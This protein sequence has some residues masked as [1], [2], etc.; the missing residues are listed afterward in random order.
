MGL[1]LTNLRKNA[2]IRGSCYMAGGRDLMVVSSVVNGHG[3]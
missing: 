2:V 1:K 3:H